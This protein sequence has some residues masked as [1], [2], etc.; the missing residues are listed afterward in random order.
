MAKAYCLAVILEPTSAAEAAFRWRVYGTAEA[1][2]L[3]KTKS[4]R[5]YKY[6]DS[7]CARMTSKAEVS[8]GFLGANN[9]FISGM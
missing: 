7:G 2:P 4:N 1:V 5:K 8:G 3:S 6:G 9:Y